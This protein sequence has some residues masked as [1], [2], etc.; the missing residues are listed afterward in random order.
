MTDQTI[1]SKPKI[2]LEKGKPSEV[3][4]KWNDFKRLLERAEDFYDLKEIKKIK[5]Q[6]PVFKNIDDILTKH[7]E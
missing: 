6:K 1:I 2:I 4:L 3:I 5:D 7:E